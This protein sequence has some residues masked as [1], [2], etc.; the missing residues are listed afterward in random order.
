MSLVKKLAQKETL[1]KLKAKT[2][3]RGK[4]W[5]DKTT[6]PNYSQIPF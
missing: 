5:E 1:N 2:L 4:K 3:D 6:P